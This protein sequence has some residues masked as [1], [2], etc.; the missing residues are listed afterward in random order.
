MTAAVYLNFSGPDA[1]SRLETYREQAFQYCEKKGYDLLVLI[2]YVGPE[3][4]VKEQ[5]RKRILQLAR[6]E[7]VDTIIVPDLHTISGFLPESLHVLQEI[8]SYGVKVED[9]NCDSMEHDIFLQHHKRMKAVKGKDKV[10]EGG[11]IFIIPAFMEGFLQ[12]A[13]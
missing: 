11:G 13:D 4:I 10:R 5:G 9:L 7:L 3:S 6:M 8:Y 12:E 2:E 1:R